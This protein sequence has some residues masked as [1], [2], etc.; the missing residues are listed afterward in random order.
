LKRESKYDS[1]FYL[2]YLMWIALFFIF[3]VILGMQLIG[4]LLSTPRYGGPVSD[5]FN[6]KRFINYGNARAKGLSDVIRWMLNRKRGMWR[7]TQEVRLGRKPDQNVNGVRITF[8][9]HTT[10][11]IQVDGINILTDPIWSKRA[12]PFEW[13]GPKR[14]RPPG[15]R[16]KDLPPIH[17]VLISHNHYDHL[18]I[19]TLKKIAHIHHSEIIVPLGVQ[20]FLERRNIIDDVKELDWWNSCVLKSQTPIEAVPAQHF[21]GRGSFDRDTSLWCGFVI[22]TRHGKIYF[23]GDTG[24]HPQTFKRIAS[25]S[26]PFRLSIIPIGAY[27]PA[28]FMGPIHCSPD[29]AVQIHLDVKSQQS[30]ASHFGTFALA[31][32]AQTDPVIDLK[33]ELKKRA[34]SDE[35][36][37]ALEEG[38]AYDFEH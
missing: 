33:S 15:I 19:T 28:W 26:G 1:F 12:S 5:H 31:D 25:T 8:I 18:D 30:I 21:S 14:M 6:G 34:L 10:F 24:Y 20:S 4:Y 29:E 16:F 27:K 3:I 17:A 22:T 32:E 35:S 7:E 38:Q 2:L 36:F 23:A 11:L 37:L 9:N 13:I